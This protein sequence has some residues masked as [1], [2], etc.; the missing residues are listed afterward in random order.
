MGAMPMV[1]GKGS[2]VKGACKNLCFL[3]EGLLPPHGRRMLTGFASQM[4]AGGTRLHFAPQEQNGC[5][6]AVQPAASNSPPDCCI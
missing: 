6:A 5:V 2:L 3:T 4:Y 1:K